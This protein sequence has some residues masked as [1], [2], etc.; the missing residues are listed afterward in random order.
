MVTV[1][2]EQGE[3]YNR[4]SIA[5]LTPLS[6]SS[7]QEPN[8][9]PHPHPHP[10]PNPNPTPSQVSYGCRGDNPLQRIRWYDAEQAHAQ[11]EG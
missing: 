6:V 2:A 8:P 1:R 4:E 7:W 5:P 9:P 11:A 10:N 3:H